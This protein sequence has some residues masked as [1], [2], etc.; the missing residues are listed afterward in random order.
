MTADLD[1]YVACI[2]PPQRLNGDPTGP[3]IKVQAVSPLDAALQA[4][5]ISSWDEP[6]YIEVVAYRSDG[7][8]T[9]CRIRI[10]M[11]PEYRKRR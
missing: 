4:L 6:G 1:D 9:A 10:M 7:D 11:E 5:V 3:S 8:G 2:C